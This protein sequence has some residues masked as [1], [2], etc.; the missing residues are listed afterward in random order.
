M[1]QTQLSP[2]LSPEVHSHAADAAASE[3]DEVKSAFVQAASHELR[4]PLGII[5]GYVELL[6]NGSLGVLSPE[7]R[8]ALFVVVNRVHELRTMVERI[9]ILLAVR[10]HASVSVPLALSDVAAQVVEKRRADTVQS[11]I[12]LVFRNESDVPLVSGD[13][14]QL[15]HAVACLVDNAIKFTPTGGRV[16]VQVSRDHDKTTEKETVCLTVSDTGIGIP[17]A[18]LERIFT[19]FYQVDGS[20]T[21]RYGGLGLGLTVAQAV[22][23]KHRGRIEANSRPGGGSKF[24]ISLPALSPEGENDVREQNGEGDDNL[25]NIM[26]VDDE[27]Y[28]TMILQGALETLPNCQITAVADG[29]EALAAFKKQAFDLLITDYKM[30]HLDGMTLATHVRRL[31]P[32]TAIIILTAYS[33]DTLREQARRL[34][35]RHVLDKPVKFSEIRHVAAEALERTENGSKEGR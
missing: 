2:Q 4:T 18:E 26:V 17:E 23:A 30:P 27:E 31:Y 9:G 8:E 3:L 25:Y 14:Y 21:R 34:S 24:A 35:I 28:I 15:E 10:S 11:G 6:H 22:V 19:G 7:Q 1:K 13:P 12:E 32:Q 5:Q 29:Q 33:D 16:E 20:T